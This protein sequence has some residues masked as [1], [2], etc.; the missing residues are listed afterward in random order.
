MSQL[1]LPGD[2][3]DNFTYW[4]VFSLSRMHNVAMVRLPKSMT[5]AI[6]DGD[7]KN[8]GI[9]MRNRTDDAVGD[10]KCSRYELFTCAWTEEFRAKSKD[11]GELDLDDFP[12]E[13]NGY[14]YMPAGTRNGQHDPDYVFMPIE[15]AK[16]THRVELGMF[17]ELPYSPFGN[18]EEAKAQEATNLERNP[19][20]RSWA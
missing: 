5:D 3:R 17:E 9:F 4:V 12:L 13:K 7:E 19:L 8:T 14:V 20:M 1:I 15:E 16:F 2:A 10:F 6:A 11:K 18:A